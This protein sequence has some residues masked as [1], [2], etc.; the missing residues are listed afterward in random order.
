MWEKN[1]F[2]RVNN[3]ILRLEN[4]FIQLKDSELKDR[5]MEI[6]REIEELSFKSVIVSM[7]NMDKFEQITDLLIT[8]GMIG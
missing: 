1:R 3:S 4:D 8:L 7:D 2:L 5:E 6:K